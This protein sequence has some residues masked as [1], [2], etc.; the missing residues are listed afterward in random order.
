MRL[1]QRVNAALD[2]FAGRGISWRGRRV[3]VVVPDAT[4]PLDADAVIAPV[5]AF[6]RARGATARIIVALGLHRR[7]RAEERRPLQTLALGFGVELTEHDAASTIERTPPIPAFEDGRGPLLPRTF[8]R[9]VLECD[10]VFVTGIVE[11]HQ[12]AG[13]SGGAKAVAIGCAGRETIAGMHGLHYLRDPAMRLGQVEANPF[14]RALERL[15]AGIP[16]IMALQVVPGSDPFVTAGPWQ[17]AFSI[18]RR[19]AAATMFE[20]VSSALDWAVLPV[21]AVKAQSFYQASRAATYVA[22]I[23]RP[24]VRKG[25][26]LVLEAACPEGIGEGAGEKA[27]AVA[28]RRGRDRLLAELRGEAEPAEDASGGAQRAYVLARALEDYQ[29][30][31]A[32]A[33]KMEAVEKLGIR[34]ISSIDELSL[35]GE[36]R[37][38][39]DVFSK[40]PRLT[41]H[42]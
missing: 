11:P 38:F 37:T 40:V 31:I 41:A 34:Q 42:N 15:V 24:A 17:E 10:L 6:L 12:Y 1:E 21:P 20:P 19:F 25:G 28:M 2:A 39:E 32:G 4:R 36:G 18:A 26:T 29:I 13:F 22:L 5:L 27:C 35:S 3:T 23:D 14:A 30:V 33:P 7:L 8:A 16:E 9:E